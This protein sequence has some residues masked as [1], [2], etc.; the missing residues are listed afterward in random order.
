MKLKDQL[1]ASNM[2]LVTVERVKPED[3]D[4]VV[5]LRPHSHQ[6][7][8]MA[9]NEESLE[10]AGGNP[11]CVP[12]IIRTQG[13]PVGFAMYAL[14]EDDQN[15]WIYRLMIDVRF[16]GRGYGRAALANIVDTLSELPDCTCVILGVKPENERARWLYERAGFR[17]TGDVINDEIVMRYDL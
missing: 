9:T 3:H 4:D 2:P 10:E 7:G 14:D 1:R 16:Q 6:M 12:L 8:Y 13:E 11:A 5:L 17:E 15:Y